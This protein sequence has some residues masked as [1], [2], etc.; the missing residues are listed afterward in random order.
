[1]AHHKSTIKRIKTNA[2]ANLRNSNYKSQLRTMLKSFFKIEDKAAA[3]TAVERYRAYLTQ[4]Q[5]LVG[6][7]EKDKESLAEK[8]AT[9]LLEHQYIFSV[10]YE[11]LPAEPRVVVPTVIEVAQQ[12]YKDVVQF[13]SRKK[14]GA[15]FFKEEDVLML[16]QRCR[17]FFR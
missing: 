16:Q 1:M 2:K 3:E 11:E 4:T 5:Q 13:L 8:M 7:A 10:I 14:K 9:A 12:H 17:H 6:S 15:L